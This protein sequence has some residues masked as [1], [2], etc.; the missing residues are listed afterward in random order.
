MVNE[1]GLAVEKI[2]TDLR[3]GPRQRRRY[4]RADRPGN[5]EAAM[6]LARLVVEVAPQ[7]KHAADLPRRRWR[8]LQR[9]ERLVRPGGEHPADNVLFTRDA[10]QVLGGRLDHAFFLDGQA[11]LGVFHRLYSKR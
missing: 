2:I 10:F 7:S 4:R 11:L 6:R 8:E 1:Y 3:H 9:V 5:V